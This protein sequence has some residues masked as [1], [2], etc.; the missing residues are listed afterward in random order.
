VSDDTPLLRRISSP[1]VPRRVINE[2][3]A[4]LR[5]WLEVDRGVDFPARRN[6]VAPF[7]N[8]A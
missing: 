6:A 1:P 3:L 7:W 2:G 8:V 4:R 5:V